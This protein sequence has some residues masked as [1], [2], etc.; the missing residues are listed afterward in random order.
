[1]KRKNINRNMICLKM[2]LYVSRCPEPERG[3]GRIGKE[4]TDKRKATH[5]LQR[6]GWAAFTLFPFDGEYL[7][8]TIY[9]G[10][11]TSLLSIFA[12]IIPSI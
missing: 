10:Y 4:Y 3:T 5:P 8:S 12:D 7:V 9:G 1:M 6:N 11:W 2:F